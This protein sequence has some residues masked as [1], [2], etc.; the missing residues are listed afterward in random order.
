M[1]NILN[2]DFSIE[3]FDSTY[4]SNNESIEG[5][6]ERISEKISSIELQQ[7]HWYQKFYDLTSTLKFIPGGRILSNAGISINGTTMINCFVDGFMG[8][9][10]DSMEGILAAL[11]RQALILKSEGGYGFCAD[12]MRPRGTYVAG[13]G[14]ETP[15]AVTML[16]MWDTQSATITEGSGKVSKNKNAKKKIR[17]GAQMVT[18]SCWHPD[19]EEFITSKQTPGRLTKFNMSVLITDEF[20]HAVKNH[21]PWDLEFPDIEME[22]LPQEVSSKFDPNNEA[23]TVKDVYKE[24][25]D[26]N[27]KTWKEEGLPTKVYKTFKDANELWDLIMESTYKRNEPGVLF[28][29]TINKLNN[30]YWEEY[31]SATNPSL[32][33]GTKVLTKTGIFDIDQ[34]EGEKF[35][36]KTINNEWKDAICK[37][38][39]KN[40]QLYKITLSTGIEY[41][42]T[43]EHKWPVELIGGGFGKIETKN[44]KETNIFAF[45]KHFNKID[46]EPNIIRNKEDGFMLGW[47]YGDGCISNVGNINQYT[48]IFSQHE[49]YIG[50]KL[51]PLINS[52]KTN[53]SYLKLKKNTDFDKCKSIQVRSIEFDTYLKSLGVDNKSILPNSV[54]NSGDEYIKGFI[55][56][57]FSADGYVDTKD[58][59]IVLTNKNKEILSD[60]SEILGFYGIKSTI[61]KQVQNNP[62]FP[63]KKKYNKEYTIYRLH[64]NGHHAIKFAKTFEFT[65]QQKQEKLIKYLDKEYKRKNTDENIIRIKSIEKTNL[66]EDVWD[67]HVFDDTHTFSLSHCITGN[68]GEQLLAIG[69]VCLLGSINLT[70]FIKN[71]TIDYDSLKESVSI[72]V[73]FM[74]N[75][76]DITYV[77][78]PSQKENLTDKRRLGLGVVGYG[79]A[80][81]M[82][83][84]RYGSKEALNLTND[85]MDK[86]KNWAY[87][88]SS[89]LAK[90]KGS[91]KLYDKEK[92]L[93]GEFIK[94][95]WPETLEMI[96]NN[97]M[98]NSHLLSI[99]PT[100]NTSS[101]ANVISSGLEPIFLFEYIRTSIVVQKP[102]GLIL[103][104]NISYEGRTYDWDPDDNPPIWNWIREGDDNLLRTEFNDVVYKLDS[105]RGLTKENLVQDYAVRHLKELNEWDP[106]ADWA[107][108]T[109]SL[110]I[111]AHI[112]T[113]EVFSRHIDSAMSKTINLPNDYNYEDFKGIYTAL[114]ETGTIKGGTTYRAGT[115]AN[116]LAAVDSNVESDDRGNE[117]KETHAPKRPANLPCDVIRFQ[118]QG[119]KWIGFIGL[120][121][122]KPYETFT[123]RQEAFSVP[124]YVENGIINRTKNGNGSRYD[125]IYTDKDG[126]QVTMQGLNRSFEREFHNTSK[127][128]SAVLRHGMPLDKLYELVRGLNITIEGAE[129]GTWKSGLMRMIK[130]YIK[131]GLEPKDTK[132]PQC[133]ESEG[134]M[135]L[136]GCIKCKHCDYSLCT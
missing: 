47:L 30:L 94:Q 130:K 77:P 39:G 112:N 87:Q 3:V 43:E 107:S 68:C 23:K 33:K 83:K 44:L 116:V 85:I 53:E 125:F 18:M 78:L 90:E 32:R 106:E 115:M 28:V 104:K 34:L 60:I 64:I 91:F 9:D 74:D 62:S 45:N 86:I 58:L 20:M 110:D 93:A 27:I 69:G 42:S 46:F 82:L 117:I 59:R 133:H 14:N 100:G 111:D 72:A 8:E 13:I 19:V 25:W 98:R 37:L 95:L 134:L 12:V 88:T 97:G 16:N 123:G 38:S 31:I 96:E 129:F 102:R 118:N 22:Y 99:Q 61:N 57:I 122:D 70:Q 56:G 10:K 5:M 51:L 105:N 136:E 101:F 114:Y 2:N 29:D 48:F 50:E 128:I 21:L 11:R 124:T 6:F 7:Q 52:Y 120:L 63:N 55:D 73:R 113:M 89:L 66:Y 119:E 108:D 103:P 26:G 76:N 71:D 15:G 17:K 4:R 41:Y 67:I 24:I 35:K 132:C 131:S 75:V 127:L 80:L 92:Y 135:Y 49:Y 54:F 126:Y 121:K 1:S 81:M 84:K 109:N 36:V 65:H 79:S 40:K